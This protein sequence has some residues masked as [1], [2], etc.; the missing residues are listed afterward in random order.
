MAKITHQAP[1]IINSKIIHLATLTNNVKLVKKERAAELRKLTL[2]FQIMKLQL[3]NINNII[4]RCTME[5]DLKKISIKIKFN[6]T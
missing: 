5:S 1:I 2:K 6:I 3:K 4:T